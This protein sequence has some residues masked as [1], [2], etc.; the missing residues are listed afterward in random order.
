[1]NIYITLDYELFLSS[2]TGTVDNC[3]IRPTEALLECLDKYGVKAN[4]FVDAAY[5]LRLSQLK[6]QAASLEKDFISVSNQIKELAQQGHSI[7]LHFHPQW[8]YSNYENGTWQMDF[9]HYKLAD[10]PLGEVEISFIESYR[11]LQSCTDKKIT[12]FRAGGYSL[13]DFARYKNLFDSLGIKTDTSVLRG[14]HCNSRYQKYD[15][16]NVPRKTSYPFSTSIIEKDETGEMIEY[17][18]TT[19]P[20]ASF[21]T[22]FKTYYT[23]KNISIEDF[24]KWGDGKSVGMDNLGSLQRFKA[25]VKLLFGRGVVP[26]SLDSGGIMLDE[27]VSKCLHRIS[28]D[29]VVIIG[30][31]KNLNRL[32]LLNLEKFINSKGNKAFK[33]F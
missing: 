8:I 4:F 6:S 21:I 12:A 20:F 10:M 30:H 7:Q 15:F 23:K 27:V 19:A 32:S 28:G 22:S 16:T 25:H 1:M 5:L 11:L 24:Q 29:D 18:I 3:L 14:K 31:P 9:D 33:V 26:A 2:Q 17:P 13:M